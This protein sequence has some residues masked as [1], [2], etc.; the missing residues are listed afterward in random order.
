MKL[1][2]LDFMKMRG[3]YVIKNMINEKYYIGESLNIQERIAHHRINRKQ[4]IHKAIRK[5]GIENFEIYVE[6][7]PDFSKHDLLKLEE[8]LI[9]KFNSLSPNGYNIIP[10]GYSRGEFRHTEESKEKI[11]IASLG[12]KHTQDTKDKLSKIKTGR[13]GKPLSDEHKRKLI[14]SNIGRRHTYTP[15]QIEKIRK[16]STGRIVSEETRRKMSKSLTGKKHPPR[17]EEWRRKMSEARKG[18]ESPFKGCTHSDETKLKMK[19][20]RKGQIISEKSNRK[21]SE[22]LKGRKFSEESKAKM[23]ESWKN[24]KPRPE[25]SEECRTKQSI[26]TKKRFE[27]QEERDKIKRFRKDN[28]FFGKTHSEETKELM[29]S[30]ALGRNTLKII[31]TDS[32]GTHIR[33]FSSIT[34]AANILNLDR[35]S[36]TRVCKGEYR[37]THGYYFKYA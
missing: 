20:S 35:S 2:T 36:I 12:R 8:E 21:R 3:V 30:K 31:Q 26:S 22:S 14:A 34:E 32:V 6:Y 15:E 29:R 5:Y 16:S 13:V 10:K 23:R 37:K 4:L 7:L 17:R 33:E 25:V 11:R 19:E 18:R 9:I 28:H 27:S 1:V 24:R